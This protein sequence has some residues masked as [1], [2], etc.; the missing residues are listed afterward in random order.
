[1]NSDVSTIKNIE[2]NVIDG[3]DMNEYLIGYSK[4]FDLDLETLEFLFYA[5][6][7]LIKHLVN[8]LLW[9]LEKYQ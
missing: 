4:L 9:I 6:K 8:L 7:G 2:V 5:E 1:L 3:L